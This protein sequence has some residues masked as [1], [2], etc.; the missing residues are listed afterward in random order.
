VVIFVAGLSGSGKTVASEMSGV[1]PIVPLDS[2]FLDEHPKLPK[3]FGRTDW[4]SIE[5]YDLDAAASSVLALA[6]G[7]DVEIPH[8]DHSAN[9]S[10][11]SRTT[12]SAG[13]FVAEGVYA[14]DVYTRAVEAGIQAALLLI[15]VSP[16][17]AFVSR[18]RRDIRE[19]RMS[20]GWAIVRSARLAL[21][22]RRYRSTVMALGATARGRD[23][24]PAQIT[25]W[26]LDMSRSI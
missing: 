20:S 17:T 10:F 25:V 3:W 18:I 1:C 11:S 8:Y 16:F 7:C 12:R 4:E 15:D 2:F 22:H 5:T 26:A 24:A 19:H 6:K 13:P 23:A 9:A 21:R 14:P